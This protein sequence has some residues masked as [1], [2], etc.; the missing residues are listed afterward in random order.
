MKEFN[1]KLES[2]INATPS[3]QAGINNIQVPGQADLLVWQT[4][5]KIPSAYEL[6]LAQYL[7]QAFS[8]GITELD[9][10]VNNLNEQ[11]FRSEAGA[12]WTVQSFSEEMQRLGY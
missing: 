7:I 5:S 10:L 1:E 6:D 9:H 12:V 8:T 4:R 3:T 11:G 2:W